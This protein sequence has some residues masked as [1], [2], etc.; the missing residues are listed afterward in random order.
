[1]DAATLF[2]YYIHDMANIPEE[3]QYT[4]KQLQQK[5]LEYDKIITQ[6]ETLE[7][8]LS[9]HIKQSGVMIRHPKEDAIT[10]QMHKL[11]KKATQIQEEKSILLNTALYNITKNTVKFQKDV[12]R[13]IE[14][15]AIDNWDVNDD[16]DDLTLISSNNAV[17]SNL[18][19]PSMT[20][21][22]ISQLSSRMN[23][24]IAEH[25]RRTNSTTGD[26]RRMKRRD[27]TPLVDDS[28]TSREFTPNRRRDISS[29]TTVVKGPGRRIPSGSN[30]ADNGNGDD[31]DLYCFC[32]QVSYGEMV[33]CDNPTCKYEWFHYDCV[34][35]KEIPNGVWYCPDC[36]KDPKTTDKKKKNM[37]V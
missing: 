3:T 2:D 29:G 12:R 36:R 7:G 19:S 31:D 23:S 17:Y 8:Q 33:A 26:T 22:S 20:K 18:D 21:G 16:L 13:L 34:G 1:M 4:L 37:K 25:S 10:S 11:C 28:S 15:G 24:G 27:K 14:S 35:L 5:D 6:I 30:N 9:K 32:Q